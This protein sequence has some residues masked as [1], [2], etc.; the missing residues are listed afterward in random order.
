MGNLNLSPPPLFAAKEREGGSISSAGG[1]FGK[2]PQKALRDK[3]IEF[4]NGLSA[5]ILESTEEIDEIS[6]K[7]VEEEVIPAKYIDDAVHLAL[8]LH[9]GMDYI[10][11]WNF[12]H[13][14]KP[15]TKKAV[16]V[17]CIKEGYKE[18]EIVTPEEVTADEPEI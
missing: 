15:K 16:R 6:Q 12:K 9:N 11:S 4:A 18:T 17:F 7:F 2:R 10:V 5:R 13:L 8:A 1:E 14:V 3:L